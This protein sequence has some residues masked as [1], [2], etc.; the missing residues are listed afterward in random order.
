MNRSS[1]VSVRWRFMAP[2]LAL[3]F[4]GLVAACALYAAISA[5]Y[6]M[7]IHT[8]NDRRAIIAAVEGNCAEAW[9]RYHSSAGI[10]SSTVLGY[11]P[12]LKGPQ[13]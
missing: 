6:A 5:L 10:S 4:A 1:S 13:P 11:C 9:T 8:D 2:T 12:R 3:C 7:S